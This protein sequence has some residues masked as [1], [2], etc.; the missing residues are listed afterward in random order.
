MSRSLISRY[1]TPSTEAIDYQA[2][3]PLFRDLTDCIQEFMQA[4][5]DTDQALRQTG[6]VEAIKKH[7]GL[8][9]D[10][11]VERGMTNAYALPILIDPNGPF[12]QPWNRMGWGDMIA[13]EVTT[14]RE[15]QRY[16]D[17][18]R[19]QIDLTSGRVSGVFSNLTVGGVLGTGLWSFAKLTAAEVAA[20]LLHELGHVFTFFENLTRTMT[21]NMILATAIQGMNR[22]QD[23]KERLELV[24]Q[25]SRSLDV[26]FDKPESVATMKGETFATLVIKKKVDQLASATGSAVYDLRG[27]E[28][29]ADQWATRQGAGRALVEALDKIYVVFGEGHRRS[30]GENVALDIVTT[31][32]A[33]VVSIIPPVGI[34]IAT[35]TFIY[36]TV[37]DVEGKQ[38]H[39]PLERVVTVRKD[40]I[41]SLKQKDLTE[42]SRKAILN[43]IAGIDAI[44]KGML[45]YRSWANWLYIRLTPGRRK[46]YNEMRFQQELEL[47]ANNDLFVHAA[48]LQ[49]LA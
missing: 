13:E 18:L 29:S 14:I 11:K 7:T 37:A 33:I 28:F 2:G 3:S 38:Y 15:I 25:V 4:P 8:S 12:V 36:F 5:R 10:L 32:A 27:A 46:Q 30:L 49:T 47:L 34:F 44:A 42:E 40:L 48:T 41:Q 23:R 26:P 22:T 20:I 43:D 9:I 16:S 21:E 6:I 45:D 1:H 31:L 35:L 17:T 24:Q 19:G 39:D